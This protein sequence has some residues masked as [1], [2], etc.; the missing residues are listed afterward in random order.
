MYEKL[1]K[2]AA[3]MTL[4]LWTV[5][6]L[7]LI[8]FEFSTMTFWVFLAISSIGINWIVDRLNSINKK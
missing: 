1:G 4:S 5:V 3:T 6:L 2:F 8:G 7:R